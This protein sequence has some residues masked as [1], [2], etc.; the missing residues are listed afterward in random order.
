MKGRCRSIVASCSAIA[1]ALGLVVTP[2][3]ADDRDPQKP[4]VGSDCGVIALYLLLGLEDRPRPLGSITSILPPST[5]SGY[6]MEEL[7]EASSAFGLRLA[8]RRFDGSHAMDRPWIV[9]LKR[10]GHG[11]FLVV[12]PVGHSGKL[13]QVIDPPSLPEVVDV[14][15]LLARSDWTGLGLTP[16]RL[17]WAVLLSWLAVLIA[18]LPLLAKLARR[19]AGRRRIPDFARPLRPSPCHGPSIG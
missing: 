16:E 4:E 11:H 2:S 9:H 10:S 3:P 6:S 7:R 13:V 12:R 17:P 8:G 18:T 15:A 5:P 1:V 19:F 14:D